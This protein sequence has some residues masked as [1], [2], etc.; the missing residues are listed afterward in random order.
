[1]RIH[2][3]T[4]DL[5]PRDREPFWRD[6]VAK[7][8][9]RVTPTDRTDPA[10]LRVRLDAQIAGRFTLYD[11]QTSLRSGERTV[12]DVARDKPG[13]FNLRRVRHKDI[14]VL[15]PKR[16]TAAELRL[17]PGDFSINCNEWPNKGAMNDGLSIQGVLIPQEFL[18]PLLA[19]GRLTNRSRCAP[20]HRGVGCSAPPSTA[21]AEI[22]WGEVELSGRAPRWNSGVNLRVADTVDAEGLRLVLATSADV[23]RPERWLL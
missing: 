7:H 3:S 20:A 4:D 14:F 22:A 1:M 9:M 11:F 15:T 17:D 8:F 16:T 19:G 12:A 2:F 10:T 18:S 21:H 5:P 6:V 23:R 13:R